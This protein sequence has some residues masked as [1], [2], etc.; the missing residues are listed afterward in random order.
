MM[1]AFVTGL[2]T[3]HDLGGGGVRTAQRF[4]LYSIMRVRDAFEVIYETING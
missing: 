2:A 4:H 1:V 3:D